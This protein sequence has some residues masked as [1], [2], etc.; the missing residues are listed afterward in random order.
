MLPP[1]RRPVGAITVEAGNSCGGRSG[2]NLLERRPRMG[3]LLT[4]PL[5]PSSM[6]TVAASPIFAGDPPAIGGYAVVRTLVPE[7]SWLAA[8]SGGRQVVLKTLDED[9]LWKGGLHPN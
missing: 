7:Q 6:D 2:R 9:C 3:K 1:S 5:S 8:A 4:A